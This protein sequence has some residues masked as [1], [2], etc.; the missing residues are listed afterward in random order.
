MH[1]ITVSTESLAAQEF[2]LALAPKTRARSAI[3]L[4]AALSAVAPEGRL[5]RGGSAVRP[6][7]AL[8]AD[9]FGGF[10]VPTEFFFPT[11]MDISRTYTQQ[12][13]LG[14]SLYR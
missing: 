10:K 5:L 9:R 11:G 13:F 2:K 1:R 7:C 3:N 4:S 6:S 14:L 8:A 12:D